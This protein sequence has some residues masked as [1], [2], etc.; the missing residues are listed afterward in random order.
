MQEILPVVA[1]M[2]ISPAESGSWP[3][4]QSDWRALSDLH[5]FKAGVLFLP[6]Y[7]FSSPIVSSLKSTSY[8][9]MNKMP[10]FFPFCYPFLSST[11]YF[12]LHTLSSS[13]PTQ[14]LFVANIPT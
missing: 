4:T 8:C 7:P 10:F 2:C 5:R 12:L 3:E 14:L 1:L 13:P 11:R 9:S 6:A